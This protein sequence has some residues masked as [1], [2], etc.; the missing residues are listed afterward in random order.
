MFW[1]GLL[2]RAYRPDLHSPLTFMRTRKRSEHESRSSSCRTEAVKE[3]GENQAPDFG[4]AHFDSI[5]VV[6]HVAG[7]QSRKR[8]RPDQHRQSTGQA[9]PQVAAR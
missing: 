2:D 5:P 1:S 3:R 8:F 4:A 9:D 6:K 7:V